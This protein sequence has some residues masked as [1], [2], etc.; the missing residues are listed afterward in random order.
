MAV[1][2]VGVQPVSEEAYEAIVQLGTKGGWEDVLPQKSQGKTKAKVDV[3]VE[4]KPAQDDST[5][6]PLSAKPVAPV[7]KKRS[8]RAIKEE[9]SELSEPEVKVEKPSSVDSKR[10]SKR[11]RK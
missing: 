4:E 9:S 7:R 10:R 11:S 6:A 3:K 1:L 5:A 8:S 2:R